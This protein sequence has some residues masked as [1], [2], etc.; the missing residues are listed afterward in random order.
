MNETIHDRFD[1]VVDRAHEKL[2]EIKPKLRGWLHLA[3]A[4]LALAAGTVLIALSP[5][6]DTRLASSVFA[7]RALILFTVSALSHR[8]TRSPKVWAFQIGRPS[9]R[10]K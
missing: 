4:P 10:G 9:G 6:R 3:T 8:G 1:D 7:A 2:S 5:T